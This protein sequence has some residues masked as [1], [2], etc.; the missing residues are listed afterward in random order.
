VRGF[1]ESLV[2]QLVTPREPGDEFRTG[3]RGDACFDSV[4]K[5]VK[6]YLRATQQPCVQQGTQHFKVGRSQ[7]D[8]FG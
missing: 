5:Q 8:G 6:A 4:L 2:A 7:I 1:A 3:M